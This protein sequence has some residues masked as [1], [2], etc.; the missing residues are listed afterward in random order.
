MFPTP[1]TFPPSSNLVHPPNSLRCGIE[2]HLGSSMHQESGFLLSFF[3]TRPTLC[4]LCSQCIH[5]F[6]ATNNT[7][8]AESFSPWLP[9]RNVPGFQLWKKFHVRHSYKSM[10]T[11]LSGCHQQGGGSWHVPRKP[12]HISYPIEGGKNARIGWLAKNSK[13]KKVLLPTTHY[14]R[15]FLSQDVMAMN[16]S[17]NHMLS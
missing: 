8:D 14:L 9:F 10:E 1:G 12:S 11:G 3:T 16:W 6:A 13:F 15:N 7:K 17:Q 5:A 2:G 4:S